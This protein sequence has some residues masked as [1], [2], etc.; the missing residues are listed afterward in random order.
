MVK[1]RANL[2]GLSRFVQEAFGE[3]TATATT[4]TVTQVQSGQVVT[5]DGSQPN[6]E[7]EDT[8]SLPTRPS[9]KRKVGLL[10]RGHEKYDA[11]GLVPF[12]THASE[13]P[14]HLQKCNVPRTRT[15]LKNLSMS[16][17]RFLAAPSLLLAVC[18]RVL[19]G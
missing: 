11:T 7:P 6:E 9:K 13:V 4:T 16:F 18:L 3:Q 10:G 8:T 1:R 2:A 5:S 17:L 19:I 15:H 14:E 12:Y